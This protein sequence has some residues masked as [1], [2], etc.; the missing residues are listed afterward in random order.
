VVAQ[1]FSISTLHSLNET[2]DLGIWAITVVEVIS[3]SDAFALLSEVNGYNPEPD[4]GLSYACARI[5]AQNTGTITRVIQMSDFAATGNDGILRRTGPIAIPDP[6]LGAAV[7]PGASTEGWIAVM[8]DDPAAAILWFDSPQAGGNWADG[9]FALG[10]AA[11]APN[12]ASLEGGSTDAGSDPGAP[13]GLGE[14]VTV[15]GWVITVDE[16][17]YGSDAWDLFDFRT[18]ALGPDNS[19]ITEGAAVHAIVRNLNPFPAFF[20]SITFEVSDWTGEP[21]DQVP[22]M[23][24]VNDVSREYMPGAS[25]EG[26][27]SFGGLAWTEYNL[28]K[29]SPFKVAGEARYI[30]FGGD[31]PASTGDNETE[32][33]AETAEEEEATP[34][35]PLDVV[36]GDIV[37]TTEDRV[38]LREEPTTSGAPLRELGLDTQL[39]VAGEPVEA[40]GYTWLPVIVVDTGEF[41]YVVI[42][43]VQAAED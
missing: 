36:E 24:V 5:T 37:M 41:G 6:L 4:E 30:T 9:L 32:P 38:N 31:P 40:D 33:D 7:E 29:V 20:S 14:T 19:W 26:W 16:V 1:E 22:T 13:A 17:L 12:V 27:A 15:G 23:T 43:F 28:L 11:S 42:D 3:G 39:E 34:S 25:G 21:W 8:V 18:Q 10:D 2:A 35:A